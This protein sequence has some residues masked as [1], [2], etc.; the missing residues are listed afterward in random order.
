MQNITYNID[1]I[2]ARI[3]ESRNVQEAAISL[4]L[5]YREIISHYCQII[6][7]PQSKQILLL[8]DNI[9]PRFWNCVNISDAVK[10]NILW[11]SINPSGACKDKS[12]NYIQREE[13]DTKFNNIWNPDDNVKYWRTLISNIGDILLPYCGHIDILPIHLSKEKEVWNTFFKDTSSSEFHMVVDLVRCTQEMLELIHPKLIVY[14]NVS[15]A[16]LLGLNDSGWM[17]YVLEPAEES[18]LDD[19]TKAKKISALRS[20]INGYWHS[21][22][23][24]GLFRIKGISNSV[25]K[26]DKTN[27]EGSYL[28]LDYQVASAYWEQSALQPGNLNQVWETIC[29]FDNR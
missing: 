8:K 16:W 29:S 11:M 7:S 27:L 28:L 13:N 4:E 2:A 22:P 1:N 23:S 17:G 24:R 15:T 20:S 18:H 6:E 19:V 14:S 12:G 21:H 26:K 5:A 10:D 25:S 9:R 3:H